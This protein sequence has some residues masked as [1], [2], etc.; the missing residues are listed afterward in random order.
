MSSPDNS[1]R[2]LKISY[3]D[4]GSL[5]FTKNLIT[6][7]DGISFW[8]K[9]DKEAILTIQCVDSN[10]SDWYATNIKVTTEYKHYYIPYSRLVKISGDLSS[11]IGSPLPFSKNF[12]IVRVQFAYQYF[13]EN[14]SVKLC[15]GSTVLSGNNNATG[16]KFTA[17]LDK[18]EYFNGE[19]VSDILLNETSKTIKSG[20]SFDL[21]A[22]IEPY[23]AVQRIIWSSDKPEI[24]SVNELG[25]VT[26]NSPGKATITAWSKDKTKKSICVVTVTESI[27]DTYKMLYDFNDSN[28]PETVIN[29][30]ANATE[31]SIAYDAALNSNAF[32]STQKKADS[33]WSAI[34]FHI[35][36]GDL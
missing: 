17:Y 19:T 25:K 13:N 18:L 21:L 34:N 1:A 14:S 23:N 5:M 2:L 12:S 4:S 11:A 6:Y 35:V 30:R 22:T 9:G 8:M 32:L 16:R 27:P 33:F 26:G 10:W 28:I 15:D 20:K 36:P 3:N 31:I 29:T 24:A 7:N